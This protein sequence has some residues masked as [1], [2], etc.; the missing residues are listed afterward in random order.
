MRAITRLC[1][2]H[3]FYL[4]LDVLFLADVFQMFRHTMIDAHGLDCLH[5][6]SLPSMML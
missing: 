5:F 3:H 1:D 4:C 2:G 6:P